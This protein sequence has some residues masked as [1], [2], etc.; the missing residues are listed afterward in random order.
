MA[1]G[2]QKSLLI[3]S[4]VYVP[5]PASLGQHMHDAA[6]EMAR[7][8][9]PVLVVTARRGYND[10]SR[11]YLRRE[12]RAGVQIRRL[13]LS[14]F[15]KR[16]IPVRLAGQSI[17]LLQATIKGLFT[18]RLG[19]ILISTSP[20]MCPAAAL[21][22]RFFRRTPVMYWAMDLNPDQL[23]VLGKLSSKSIVAKTFDALN[24][25]ILRRAAR[26][27]SLDRYM[28]Q[29][30]ERKTAVGER[31]S[32][33]PPWPHVDTTGEIV[34]HDK[35]PFR[36]KYDLGHKFVFMYSGNH[37]IALPLATFLQAAV[38]FKHDPNLTFLFVGDG[39][40]KQEVERT[41]SENSMA[42]MMSLPYQPIE[43][44]GQSL[45]A[46]DIHLVS[47][48]DRMVGVIH[49]CKIYGAMAVGRPI[50][51]LGPVPCHLSDI[52]QEYKIGWHIRHGDVAGAVRQIDTIR[53]TDPAE[54]QCM[55]QRAREAVLGRLSKTILCSK[56]CD[57]I[58]EGMK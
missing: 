25:M 6:A 56:F 8:G 28:A 14:S 3:I 46:A 36:T 19:A 27:V 33:M 47:M 44:L 34:P 4:Q 58:E 11:K 23:L 37:G 35:N 10:P 57:T 41:I 15:G 13:P 50:L 39:I 40:R 22:I 17:F 21:L 18:R 16:S 38:H 43:S 2:S 51:L 49:P 32:V 5:D 20:P 53:R 52:I 9:H 7:R 45:S 54:L 1:T 30:L 24:R 31:M 42:N 26:V 48:D 55:G 12:N 29:S